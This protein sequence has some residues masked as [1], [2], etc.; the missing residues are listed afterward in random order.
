M[1]LSYIAVFALAA[2]GTTTVHAQQSEPFSLFAGKAD[3][4]MVAAY[5]AKDTAN[6]RRHLID[7]IDRYGQLEAADK[8]G[9]KSM[10]DNAYYNFSCTYA[11]VGDKPHALDCLEKSEYYDY[12]HLQEDHDMDA[13]RKED[14]FVKY[15]DK[16]KKMGG[17]YKGGAFKTPYKPN[18]TDQEKL[19]GLSQL[20]AQA[21]YNFVYFDKLPFDWNQS[22]IDY[23]P[24][25]LA[26]KSTAEY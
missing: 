23:I 18:I 26:T 9:Y 20:W 12:E 15:M 19:A 21:K 3:S 17:L 24:K 16:A 14:R 1:K 25:V 6:Y 13:L 7:F 4:M 2:A 11:L 8:E 10:L 22:Y 5:E